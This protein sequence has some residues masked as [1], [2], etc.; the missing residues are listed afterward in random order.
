MLKLFK[1]RDNKRSQA[2]F[3]IMELLAALAILVILG[4]MVASAMVTA[5][6][7]M[8]T[9][10]AASNASVL[11]Q[12]IE[13]ALSDTLRY[14]S[15]HVP[16]GNSFAED[17]VFDSDSAFDYSGSAVRNG[18]LGV[19]EG[20]IALFTAAGTQFVPKAA[21]IYTDFVISDFK[22]FYDCDTNVY[23]GTYTIS[24]ANGSYTREGSFVCKTL[25]EET[26][27]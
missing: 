27:E 9:G 21:G 15:A 7:V 25:V 19:E 8:T 16:L 20:K 11:E 1:Q 2:G 5:S 14:A 4:T 13:T 22:M 3:T 24:T 12:S 26:Y 23:N 10:T 17:P 6:R 18:Q